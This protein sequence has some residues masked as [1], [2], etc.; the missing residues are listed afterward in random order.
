MILIITIIVILIL[1]SF[2]AGI[3]IGLISMAR[4]RLRHAAARGSTSAR[5]LERMTAKPQ[6][7]IATTLLG[8]NLCI[9]LASILVDQ[10]FASFGFSATTALISS[11]LVMTMLL[12]ISEIV[13]KDWFRQS[14]EERCIAFAPIYFFFGIILWPGAKV[15]SWLTMVALKSFS[16]SADSDAKNTRKLLRSDFRLLLRDSK[17]AGSLDSGEADILEKSLNFNS[18]HIRDIYTPLEQLTTIA[19]DETISAAIVI[20]RHSGKS[21]L[22]IIKNGEWKGFFSLYDAIYRVVESKW[23]ST[24]VRD[25]MRTTESISLDAPIADALKLTRRNQTRML[26]VSNSKGQNIGVVTPTDVARILFNQH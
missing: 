24:T 1:N 14:P 13:P 7:M 9:V 18:Q 20:C 10:L 4:P 23:D 25:C 16:T 19:F 2:F 12:M 26:F 8:S 6:L 22:P 21:R 17:S 3:E 5:L 15:L 11:T